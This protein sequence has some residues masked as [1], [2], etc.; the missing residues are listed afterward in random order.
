MV[1]SGKVRNGVVVLEGG[2]KLAEGTTVRVEPIIDDSSYWHGKSI[3]EL[4]RE[5]GTKP[6]RSLDELGSKLSKEELDEMFDG[7]DEWL[8]RSRRNNLLSGDD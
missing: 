7:F 5:Q 8:A 3:E 6:V 2:E 1:Y 4:A